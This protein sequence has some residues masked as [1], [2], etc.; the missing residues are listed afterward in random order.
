MKPNGAYHPVQTGA[1][2]FSTMVD[3]GLVF[4]EMDRAAETNALA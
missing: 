2:Y 3:I 4:G 1:S